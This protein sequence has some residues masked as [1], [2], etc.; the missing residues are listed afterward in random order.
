MFQDS[1][2]LDSINYTYGNNF[3]ENFENKDKLYEI[4][5]ILKELES[6]KTKNDL[7]LI[8]N[9][10]LKIITNELIESFNYNDM[11]FFNNIYKY[12]I[13]I[14]DLGKNF[15]EKEF[16]IKINFYILKRITKEVYEEINKY[17]EM[18]NSTDQQSLYFYLW[19]KFLDPSKDKIIEKHIKYYV[20]SEEDFENINKIIIEDYIEHLLS[21]FSLRKIKNY[22]ENMS[23]QTI[24][25]GLINEIFY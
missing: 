21:N 20:S 14:K 1:E 4:Y 10:I 24:F 18:L 17:K 25:F 8:Y 7:I 11:K 6:C 9:K 23:S 19:N 3:L 5:N 13:F 22:K 15:N 2:F 12:L 16:K